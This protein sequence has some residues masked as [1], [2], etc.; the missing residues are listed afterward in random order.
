MNLDI[1]NWKP[2]I[3]TFLDFKNRAVK[4]I[5]KILEISTKDP[6][7]NFLFEKLV[8]LL[9][10][11]LGDDGRVSNL[12][13]ANYSL[14]NLKKFLE[15]VIAVS[16]LVQ[17]YHELIISIPN[18]FNDIAENI[19]SDW[20]KLACHFLIFNVK[21]KIIED[22]EVQEKYYVALP[23]I[24]R[25]LND[26]NK[27]EDVFLGKI[28]FLILVYKVFTSVLQKNKFM[29][30]VK[31]LFILFVNNIHNFDY[32]CWKNPLIDNFYRMLVQV[33]LMLKKEDFVVKIIK[34]RLEYFNMIKNSLIH[35]NQE[36]NTILNV[37]NILFSISKN[38]LQL[39]D[40]ENHAKYLEEASQWLED[41]MKIYP[42][43]KK[44]LKMKV[45]MIRSRGHNALKR[46][47][48]KTCYQ[49]YLKALVLSYHYKLQREYERAMMYVVKYKKFFSENH[50]PVFKE[51]LKII[52]EVLNQTHLLYL[53]VKQFSSKNQFEYAVK[54]QR[55]L[56]EILEEEFNKQELDIAINPPDQEKMEKFNELKQ[57]LVKNL[58][59]LGNLQVKIKRLDDAIIS[60]NKEANLHENVLP[61][62]QIKTLIKIAKELKKANRI[63]DSIKYAEQALQVALKN[64]FNDWLEKALK[65]LMDLCKIGD[66]PS[67]LANYK[68]MYNSIIKE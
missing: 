58:D 60:F 30:D 37:I 57:L 62:K 10:L 7:F 28:V 42:F 63:R 43:S 31:D 4:K 49:Y 35:K 68:K 23:F 32:Q 22:I 50:I 25:V 9:D 12:D 1:E 55:L 39:G 18:Y 34:A 21:V 17:Q 66:L 53:I 61:K 54:I 29:D 11:Q 52:P 44:A 2:E 3:D 20:V 15:G 24:E 40:T 36:T 64:N 56:V 67:K 5:E 65:I 33:G 14:E 48:F 19:M 16:S 47:D 46:R 8:G 41:Q 59:F 51:N 45:K 13:G 26:L 27:K 6:D 38:Y